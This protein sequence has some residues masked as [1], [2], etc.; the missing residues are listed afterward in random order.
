MSEQCLTGT[1]R[2]M[3]TSL[4]EC[5]QYQIPIGESFFQV[6][7]RVGSCLEIRYTG[8]INCIACRREIT[9][10]FNQGYCYPCY[11][12]LAECDLCILRP[13]TCHY[14]LGTC[15]DAGWADGHCMQD[16]VVYLANTS[17]IKVGI[18]RSEQIPNRWIDQGARQ[19]IAMFRVK[20]RFHSGLI[21]AAIGKQLSDRTDWRK[22]LRGHPPEV[23]MQKLR[24]SVYREFKFKLENLG[25]IHNDFEWEYLQDDPILIDYP[26]KVFPEKVAALN[27]DKQSK[28]CGQLTG[29]KGQYLIMDCGVINIRKF[30]GYEVE[31]R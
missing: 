28:I 3:V 9:K 22:M 20:S 15:R 23:D 27:L 8:N 17:G 18:T 14:H 13:E 26:V 29:I 2:K 19:A 10:T 5:V 4:R 21:E 12:S 1:L 25:C 24:T 31:V 16:H 11:R 6:S 30:S 7:E